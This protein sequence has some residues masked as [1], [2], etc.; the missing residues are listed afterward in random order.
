M[1]VILAMAEKGNPN[2][3]SDAGVGALCV[4]SGALGAFMHVKI[5]ARELNDRKF[6]ENKISK[7]KKLLEEI[8][9][10]EKKIIDLVESKI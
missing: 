4:R 9:D 8:R 7:G 3:I 5:N 10:F 2:S 6:A 1:P